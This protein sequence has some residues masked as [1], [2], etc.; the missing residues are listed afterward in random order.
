MFTHCHNSCLIHVYHGYRRLQGQK[1][2]VRECSGT[3]TS[4]IRVATESC[5][6]KTPP[7]DTS[8]NQPS[9]SEANKKRNGHCVKV[10]WFGNDS[11]H[12]FQ[13]GLTDLFVARKDGTQMER[14]RLR[15]RV[16]VK[17]SLAS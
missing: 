2:W 4:Y 17:G 10:V 14:Y 8:N 9:G 1:Q 6:Q 3:W 5:H 16:L 15:K 12:A 11:T 7:H 13:S